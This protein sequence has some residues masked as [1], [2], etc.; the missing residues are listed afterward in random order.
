VKEK[1]NTETFQHPM[2]L[3]SSNLLGRFFRSM[4]DSSNL[5]AILQIYGGYSSNLLGLF[6]RSIGA[7]LQ[8]FGSVGTKRLK[9]QDDILPTHP[10]K[11]FVRFTY[12]VSTAFPRESDAASE[13]AVTVI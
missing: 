8:T 5:W 3:N 12:G 9:M 6:F 10:E 13:S 7:I 11:L 4:A 1:F 2:P